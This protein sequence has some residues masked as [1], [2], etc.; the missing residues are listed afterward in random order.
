[1]REIINQFTIKTIVNRFFEFK[2]K[3]SREKSMR[4]IMVVLNVLFRSICLVSL[5]L[6]PIASLSNHRIYFHE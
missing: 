2:K 4:T 5:T 3:E 6:I 1:M